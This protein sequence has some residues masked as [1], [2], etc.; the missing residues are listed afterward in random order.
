MPISPEYGDVCIR[1]YKIICF[2]WAFTL[3]A[4]PSPHA[5]GLYVLMMQGMVDL[6]NFM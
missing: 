5:F 1:S 3:G 4:T 6:F 2:R